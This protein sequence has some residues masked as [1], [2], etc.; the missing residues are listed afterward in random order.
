MLV[1]PSVS[2]ACALHVTSFV[3]LSFGLRHRSAESGSASL[4]SSAVT[5]PPEGARE[6]SGRA[7][8]CSRILGLKS[9]A[10]ADSSGN[11]F[12]DVRLCRGF[13]FKG[14]EPSTA[15]ASSGA[16]SDPAVFRTPELHVWIWSQGSEMFTSSK[17][18]EMY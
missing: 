10:P 11:L 13:N 1:A 12:G 3:G 7:G 18:R 2:Q 8:I 4:F 16:P 6:L 9:L 17:C 14:R 5:L 15:E